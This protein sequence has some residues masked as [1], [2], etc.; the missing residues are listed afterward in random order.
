MGNRANEKA[1]EPPCPHYAGVHAWDADK[2]GW[3][4]W[5]VSMEVVWST[6]RSP[7]AEAG[8]MTAGWYLLSLSSL[9]LLLL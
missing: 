1:D 4:A 2:V 5:K 6:S 7:P 3:Q 9:L 8:K